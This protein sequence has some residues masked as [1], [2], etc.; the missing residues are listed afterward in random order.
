MDAEIPGRRRTIIITAVVISVLLYFLGV[1]SGLYANRIVEKKTTESMENLRQYISVMDAN[2]KGMQLEQS[3]IDTLEQDRRCRY[4]TL[5]LKRLV[6]QLRIY[7]ENLPFR[8]E[9]YEH[10]ERPLSQEYLELKKQYTQL[11]LRTWLTARDIDTRCGAGPMPVLYLYDTDCEDC[12]RQGEELDRLQWLARADN[13]SILVLTVDMNQSE[14]LIESL[15]MYYNV[16]SAP[17]IIIGDR[18]FEGTLVS[19]EE[20]YTVNR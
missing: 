11:S 3:F 18:I 6:D 8:I 13:I 15:K 12:V 14:A 4:S 7:W 5:S 16:S 1:M 17:V 2:L 19:A 9:E 20:L 10:N